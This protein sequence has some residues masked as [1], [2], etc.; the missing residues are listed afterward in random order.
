MDAGGGGGPSRSCLTRCAAYLN[1][2]R[3]RLFCGTRCKL[4]V[5]CVVSSFDGI[6]ARQAPTG[7][8]VRCCVGTLPN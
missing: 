5:F 3:L 6:P 4:S 7:Q 2:Q 1:F 8:E